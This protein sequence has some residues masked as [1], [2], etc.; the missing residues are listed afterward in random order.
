MSISHTS[1]MVGLTLDPIGD[2]VAPRPILIICESLPP[3]I[4]RSYM[5][6]LVALGTMLILRAS[7]YWGDYG[8]VFDCFVVDC[9]F[10]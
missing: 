2:P 8:G 9:A 4:F 5:L 6:C 7:P 10:P 3:F 1:T